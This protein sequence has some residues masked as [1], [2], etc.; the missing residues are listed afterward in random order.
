LLTLRRA[1]PRQSKKLSLTS[2]LTGL[3]TLVVLL[4]SSILLIGSYESKKQSLMET[5]LHLNYYNAD[6][7]TKTMDSLF[8]S[9]RSSLEYSAATL[10]D[11]DASTPEQ[12]DDYLELMRNSSNYFNSIAVVDADGLLRNVVPA[13]LGPVGDRI[14]SKAGLEALAIK[15]PYISSPYMTS[16]TKRLIVFMSQ[17]IFS[18]NGT[19][20]ICWAFTTKNS[21]SSASSKL[22]IGFQNTPVL[23]IAM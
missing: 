11:D 1:E 19:A 5:T 22:T 16:T 6:R 9:M 10:S 18:N 15:K 8:Q 21:I 2:L 23:S 7:M 13:S 3:V 20:F 12:V 17:P 14:T 4:T